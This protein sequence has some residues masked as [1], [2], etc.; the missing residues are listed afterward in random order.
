MDLTEFRGSIR[1]S[2]FLFSPQVFQQFHLSAQQ[3]FGPRSHTISL[4]YI[5]FD[6]LGET[7]AAFVHH[8]LALFWLCSCKDGVARSVS[9]CVD[10]A[11]G[12]T[13]YTAHLRS[14]VLTTGFTASLLLL[15]L[16]SF[17]RCLFRIS[18]PRIS[19][20][21]PARAVPTLP[22]IFLPYLVCSI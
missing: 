2:S 14:S 3:H 19:Q 1:I 21:T 16:S 12:S 7:T 9:T 8:S 13:I 6:T 17:S 18:F 20:Y 11:G 4:F 22:P 10:Q 5:E 15:S